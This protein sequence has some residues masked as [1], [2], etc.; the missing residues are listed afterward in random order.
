MNLHLAKWLP[1]WQ[2]SVPLIGISDATKPES[3]ERGQQ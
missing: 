3:P 2:R 1:R